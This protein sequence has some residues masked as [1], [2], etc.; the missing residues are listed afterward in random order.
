MRSALSRDRTV[1]ITT[2]GRKT[3]QP[4]T[5]EIWFHRVG[6]RYY[7]S[8]LPG[9]RDWLANLLADPHFVFSFTES[10]IVRASARAW[11]VDDPADRRRI[12]TAIG[13]S[14]RLGNVDALIVG[15]PLIEFVIDE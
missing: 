5:V 9:K 4:R 3:R 12:L 8:G 15:S 1:R 14:S 6:G 10:A 2:T 13:Q 11:P 7:L